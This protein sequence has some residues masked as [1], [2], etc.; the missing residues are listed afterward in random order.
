MKTTSPSI[1]RIG[2][3]TGLIT[4]LA[5]IGYFMLM[6]VLGL[7]QILEL[8]FFNA[9]ILTVGVCY[10]IIKLKRE[11][12]ED[13]FYLKGLMQGL[14]ISVVA[15]V[16]FGLFMSFY[17]SYFDLP[18]LEHIRQKSTVG[19]SING[20]S[21]FVV[22]FM[23]GMASSVIITF[24]AMQYFKRAGNSPGEAVKK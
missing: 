2:L 23:E 4:S 17:L 8:R 21:V 24:A 11:L 7:E 19:M 5:L 20:V 16:A 6:K 18:L 3:V 14:Y 10:G 1:E 15:V 13:E 9:I 22:I 12:H